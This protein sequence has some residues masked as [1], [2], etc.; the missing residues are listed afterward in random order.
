[1]E[2]KNKSRLEYETMIARGWEEETEE[3]SVSGLDQGMFM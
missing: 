2:V 3:W 1:M